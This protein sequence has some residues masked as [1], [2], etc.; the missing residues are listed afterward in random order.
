MYVS[1]AYHHVYTF[2]H[3]QKLKLNTMCSTEHW[4]AQFRKSLNLT[5]F[6]R[7]F[8]D[9]DDDDCVLCKRQSFSAYAHT[10]TWRGFS[11][12]W[13]N[14]LF[15]A[16]QLFLLSVQTQ[17]Q[18]GVDLGA[19]KNL[20]TANRISSC[21]IFPHLLFNLPTNLVLL[22]LLLLLRKFFPHWRST[23]VQT[24]KHSH[25]NKRRAE[26]ALECLCKM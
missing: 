2:T 1:F 25:S 23:L 24:Y 7:H 20:V 26:R 12:G 4:C 19:G 22:L 10:L 18:Q 21:S 17:Q 16:E 8:C 5:C 6:N 3:P 11:C 9:D 13:E 14:K 15:A